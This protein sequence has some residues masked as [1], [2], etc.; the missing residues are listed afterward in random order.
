MRYF[1]VM[2][3][4]AGCAS[5]PSVKE[6]DAEAKAK[7]DAAIRESCDFIVGPPRDSMHYLACMEMVAADMK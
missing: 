2:L 5:Q 7:K 1:M 4:L 6:L 3:L